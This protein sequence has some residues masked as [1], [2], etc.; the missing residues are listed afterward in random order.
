VREEGKKRESGEGVV[1]NTV[2]SQN[3]CE[4]VFREEKTR[5]ENATVDCV[6][7]LRSRC[8]EAQGQG[9]DAPE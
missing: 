3:N 6:R 4:G 7:D 9:H 5:K 1:A 2:V 8:K